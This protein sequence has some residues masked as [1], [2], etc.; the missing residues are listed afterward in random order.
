MQVAKR[1][2]A[3]HFFEAVERLQGRRRVLQPD[4]APGDNQRHGE[5]LSAV[6]RQAAGALGGGSVIAGLCVLKQEDDVREAGIAVGAGE[7]LRQRHRLGELTL[8]DAQ[9]E[10]A[11]DQI[12]VVGIL[13]E[14]VAHERRRMSIVALLLRMARREIAAE[15]ACR[16]RGCG[17]RGG[18]GVRLG[19]GAGGEQG[20]E[21]R[22][23]RAADARRSLL[24]PS[25][26]RHHR[27]ASKPNHM[28]G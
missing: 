4:L 20:D 12:E 25:L 15:R 3:A 23:R 18:A 6:A 14:R 17:G 8:A 2:N 9:H 28:F 27:Y 13:G 19:R 21:G 16:R 5:S 7:A 1:L 10:G 11:A 22:R 24:C 26:R